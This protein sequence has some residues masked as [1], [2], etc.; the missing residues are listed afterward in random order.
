MSD[1]PS[2]R[3]K[4]DRP[5][6][7]VS[8]DHELRYWTEKFR[9]SQDEL[10]SAVQKLGPMATDVQQHLGVGRMHRAKRLVV[11]RGARG[12]RVPSFDAAGLQQTTFRERHA[13]GAAYDEMVENLHVDQSQC[14]LER[15]SQRLV[16]TAVSTL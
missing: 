12:G 16:R 3:G 15:L 2:K 7:N 13:G 4:Q 8:E 6:I 1:D 5:R 10:K 11:A 9:V 14:V